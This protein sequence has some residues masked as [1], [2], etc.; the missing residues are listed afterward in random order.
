MKILLMN[1][2][3]ATPAIFKNYKAAHDAAIRK[4][5]HE[6]RVIDERILQY[7]V[8]EVYGDD[9][10]AAYEPF[11]GV[12]Y[13]HERAPYGTVVCDWCTVGGK[14]CEDCLKYD[15]DFYESCG[16]PVDWDNFFN[17]FEKGGL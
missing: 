17:W 7:Y 9:Y 6:H 2:A 8:E 11:E 3:K 13:V 15:E 1:D 16:D 10:Y 14:F 4:V 5:V 12:W